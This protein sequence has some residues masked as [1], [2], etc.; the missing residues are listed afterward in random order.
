MDR[1]AGGASRPVTWCAGDALRVYCIG[2]LR[3]RPADGGT[4]FGGL[5]FDVRADVVVEA[6]AQPQ[7]DPIRAD[8]EAK[9]QA[10]KERHRIGRSPTSYI[11]NA[12]RLTPSSAAMRG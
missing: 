9:E 8:V 6:A 4:E 12:E 7:R 3:H 1:P 10:D 11:A 2:P 5:G